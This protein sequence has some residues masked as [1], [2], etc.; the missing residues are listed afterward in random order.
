MFGKNAIRGQKAFVYAGDKLLVT[1][2]FM[3][4]QGEG[5][6]AG[7]PA[8]FIRLAYCNLNCSFCDTFFDHGDWYTPDA[9]RQEIDLRIEKYFDAAFE[10]EVPSWARDGGLMKRR[11][12]VLVLTGGEPMLQKSISSFLH[13]MA[14]CFEET[15][16]ESNGI[17]MQVIPKS[18]VLVVSPKC[19][20]ASGKYI[21]PN[22]RAMDRADALKFVISA[23]ESS[24]YHQIP[25]WAFT[26]RDRHKGD[27]FV[28]PMNVYN[29]LPEAVLSTIAAAKPLTIEQ[30]STV[31]EVVSFWEE[32]LLNREQNQLNH[33][34]AARY[35]IRNGLRLNLQMQ[36]YASLA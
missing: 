27:V 24:P 7:R 26:W 16:I 20:E 23:D 13:N 25:D 22:W 3:T 1:S 6:L 19:H 30:R 5:P 21:E 18:T 29:R 14:L 17:L 34:Y 12:M 11:N 10:F 28:S 4:L 32:G 36:L 9:L 33:E 35:A 8:F 2:M 15:Q 31:S